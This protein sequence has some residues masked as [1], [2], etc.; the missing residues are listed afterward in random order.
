MKLRYYF[1]SFILLTSIICC[2]SK[3][4]LK[5]EDSGNISSFLELFKKTDINGL[6][7]YSLCDKPNGKKFQGVEIDSAYYPLLGDYM[8]KQSNYLKLFAVSKFIINDNFFGLILRVPSQ[9][10][11]SA[12]DLWL[13]DSKNKRLF[14]SIELADGF[15]DENWYFNKD[16]WF[17]SNSTS[18]DIISRK[19]EHEIN[20]ETMVDSIISDKI[21]YYSFNTN[22][23]INIDTVA[24][25]ITK[26]K[27]FCE[28]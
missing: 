23:F 1:W 7:V 18:F 2:K 16:S 15:G 28:K 6:Q 22:R 25:D 3:N 12:L 11:E 24:L 19:I 9:Y 14:H 8:K 10:D 17:V 13:Y 27:L 20:E 21:D 4:D 5:S 26:F